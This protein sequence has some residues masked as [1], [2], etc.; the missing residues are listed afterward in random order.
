MKMNV[1]RRKRQEQHE[2][3]FDTYSFI[4]FHYIF[5]IFEKEKTMYEECT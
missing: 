1:K 5:K 4:S 3:S 2:T